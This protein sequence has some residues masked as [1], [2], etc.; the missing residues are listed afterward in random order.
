MTRFIDERILI[1][2]ILK[3]HSLLTKSQIAFMD[4]VSYQRKVSKFDKYQL[5]T[6]YD[7]VNKL[8]MTNKAKQDRIR[9]EQS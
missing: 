8:N 4:K 6:I 7:Y 3:H 9:R 5:Y 1:N 2:K